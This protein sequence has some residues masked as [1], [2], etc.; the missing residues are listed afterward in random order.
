MNVSKYLVKEDVSENTK[1]KQLEII[2]KVNP[3]PNS[4]NTW[5]RQIDDIKTL[6][7]TL[8]DSDRADAD[9]LIPT[10]QEK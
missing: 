6:Y 7:E 2:E 8:D 4:Y 3:A 1:Q 9:E 10:L 5:I